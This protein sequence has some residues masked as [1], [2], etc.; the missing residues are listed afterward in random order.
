MQEKLII[1]L[2]TNDYSK[3]SW[4]L[5]NE[6]GIRWRALQDDAS[7]LA[8]I[9]EGKDVIV[10]VPAEDV[11]L[12]LVQLPKMNRSRLQQALPYALEEQLIDDV[13]S[14]HFATGNNQ[15][16]NE[17]PVAVVSHQ[18]MQQWL[19]WLQS[20]NIKPDVLLPV[21]LAMPLE[22]GKTSVLIN[23]TVA[24]R[25]H[26]HQGFGCDKNNLQQLTQIVSVTE[27]QHVKLCT[28]DDVVKEVIKTTSLN[29]LQ[30]IYAVRKTKFFQANKII[31]VLSYLATAFIILL[32]LYPMV[33][34]VILKQR[35]TDIDTHINAIYKR[36]FSQAGSIIAPKE[37]MEEKLQRLQGQQ[38]KSH[39][40]LLAGYVGIAM[41]HAQAITLKRMDFQNNQLTLELIATSSEDFSMFADA[42][43]Q[44]GLQV[45]Q[46]HASLIGS[47]IHA[48]LVVSA[49]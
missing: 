18:K 22:D 47:H 27:T 13:A 7:S 12:T 8:H 31:R 24:V 11:L 17:W 25:T 30:G 2:S 43:I 1:Y 46:Q 36:Q 16:N 45:K 32:F 20:W 42:L 10:I 21:S 23:D 40:L 34:Y 5:V 19:A 44:Q 39:F 38:G 29:L 49:M 4:F 26:I 37:R 41:Q 6:E 14:L 15:A 3:S 9:A 28:L 33:S 48:T 35:L